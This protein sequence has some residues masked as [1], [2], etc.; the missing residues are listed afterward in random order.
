MWQ[1][2]VRRR[3]V[4]RPM[5]AKS[6]ARAYPFKGRAG[7]VLA[8]RRR[9][10]FRRVLGVEMKNCDNTYYD[11]IVATTASAEADPTAPKSCLNAIALGDAATERDGRK[12]LLK[13]LQLR[14][15]VMRDGAA[16]QSAFA[17]GGQYRVVVV[18]DKQTNKAQLNSEDV[19]LAAT[20]V[21]HAFRNLQYASRF[22]V[23]KDVTFNLDAI[24]AGTDGANTFATVGQSRSFN[25]YLPL[26]IPVTF[27]GDDAEIASISDN[28]LHV[29]CFGSDT[30]GILKYESRVRYVG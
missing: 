12:V 25:W 24:A 8:G 28:S 13:S 27:S 29:V 23:L 19:F 4:K 20:N 16:A 30:K 1:R 7:A 3:Y 22:R 18:L 9:T 17:D 14:G 6:W 11:T 2:N 10:A 26:A 5:A 15:S 21:E